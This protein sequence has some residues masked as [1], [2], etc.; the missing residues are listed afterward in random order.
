MVDV[1]RLLNAGIEA[2]VLVDPLVLPSNGPRRLYLCRIPL[3]DDESNPP[4]ISNFAVST[5]KHLVE[6]GTTTAVVGRA[7]KSRS[8][9]VCAIVRAR[10]EGRIACDVLKEIADVAPGLWTALAAL[11]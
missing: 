7:G 9:A 5:V 6:S 2:L 1:R 4:S 11:A 8:A 3:A 10:L